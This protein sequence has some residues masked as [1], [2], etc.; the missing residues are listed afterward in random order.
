MSSLLQLWGWVTEVIQGHGKWDS[1]DSNRQS[2]F[3]AQV[4]GITV[5]ACRDWRSLGQLCL[6]NRRMGFEETD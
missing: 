6:S 3:R 4:L 2:G 5:L 1:R